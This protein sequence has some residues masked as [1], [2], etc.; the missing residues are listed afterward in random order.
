MKYYVLMIWEDVELELHGP[1]NTRA[2]RDNEARRLRKEH[3]EYHGYYRLQS[4]GD[5][6][7][8]CFFGWEFDD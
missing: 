2:E 1:F 5:I 7:V 3:G 6:D 4:E 8:D